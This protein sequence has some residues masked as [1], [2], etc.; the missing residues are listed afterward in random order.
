MIREHPII[1]PFCLQSADIASIIKSKKDLGYKNVSNDIVIIDPELPQSA[2]HEKGFW[3]MLDADEND[4]IPNE[5]G[6][7]DEDE[8][9]EST[10]IS[11]NKVYK[12]ES[13]S[14][15]PNKEHWGSALNYDM[16][17]PEQVS[18]STDYLI[19]FLLSMLLKYVSLC[20]QQ[21]APPCH[22]K[23]K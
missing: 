15:V 8:D 22:N 1:L 5:A 4:V 7:P 3:H 13:T 17:S 18:I 20:F 10:I 16:L 19:I 9:Y 12:V 14:L 2:E 11:T 6:P 23:L 21:M